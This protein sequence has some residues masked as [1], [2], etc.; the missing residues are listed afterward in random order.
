MKYK[1]QLTRL[2]PY[3]KINFK[4]LIHKKQHAPLFRVFNACSTVIRK[5][6]KPASIEHFKKTIT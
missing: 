1:T 5:K 3:L 6:K 2:E 4:Q